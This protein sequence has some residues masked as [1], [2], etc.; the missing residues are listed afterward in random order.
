M[1]PTTMLKNSKTESAALI[2]LLLVRRGLL[3][4]YLLE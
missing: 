4:Q 1:I 2:M 3:V